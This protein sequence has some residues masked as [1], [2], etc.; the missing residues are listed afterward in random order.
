MACPPSARQCDNLPDSTSEYAAQGTDAHTL[1][2]ERLKVALGMKKRTMPLKKLAYYDA[3]M[4]DCA[5]EY[6]AFVLEQAAG[7]PGAS[8]FIE[9]RVDMSRWVPEASGTCDCIIIGAR[10]LHIVDFKYGKGVPVEAGNNPQFMLYALG[11]LEAFDLLYD[12]ETVHMSVFQPRLQNVD[13]C[14]MTTAALYGWAEEMLKP[15]A[16]LAFAGDGD[17]CAGDH[18]RFCKIKAACRE[19][20]NAN[21]VLAAYEFADP[22][23][24]EN[25]EIA[26]ILSK[27]DGLVAWASDVKEFALTEALKGAE[28]SGF[29]IVEGRSNRVFTDDAKVADTLAAGGFQGYLSEPKLLGITAIEKLVGKTRLNELLGGYITKPQGKP[30]LVPEDDKRPALQINTAADDFAD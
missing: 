10:V 7:I 12:I 13:T 23:L 11:A 19:R 8:V 25:D 20:A 5:D 26:A 29:K 30:V 21:L 14:E 27:I 15:A 4:S 3:E 22:A 2:E 28:F 16:A 1:C 6:V 18:C 24:L 17:F 9:Q